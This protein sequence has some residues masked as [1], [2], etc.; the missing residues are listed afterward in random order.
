VSV[1]LI[2]EL[3]ASMEQPSVAA[4]GRRLYLAHILHLCFCSPELGK[5]IR[6]GTL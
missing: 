6:K 4:F 5:L 1:W 3:F 2:A